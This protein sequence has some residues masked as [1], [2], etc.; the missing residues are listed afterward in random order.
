VVIVLALTVCVSDDDVLVRKFPSPLYTARIVWLPGLRADV[1][2]VAW[3]VASSGT[4]DKV[5]EP[6]RN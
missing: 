1:V 6:S 5:V 3:P 4:V 2:K